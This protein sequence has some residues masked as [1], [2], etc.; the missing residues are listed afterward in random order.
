MS[1]LKGIR[2][3]SFLIPKI[4]EE[5]TFQSNVQKVAG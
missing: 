1:G 4:T 3:N 2:T 5:F